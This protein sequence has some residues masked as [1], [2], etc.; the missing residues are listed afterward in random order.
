MFVGK[1]HIFVSKHN[2]GSVVFSFNMLD[3]EYD[4]QINETKMYEYVKD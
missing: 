2:R 4:M 3:I 1:L